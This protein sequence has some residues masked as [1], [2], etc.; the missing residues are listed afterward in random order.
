M[1][2]SPVHTHTGRPMSYHRSTSIALLLAALLALPAA[3]AVVGANPGSGRVATAT[4]G[5]R[6]VERVIVRWASTAGTERGFSRAMRMT[7]AH[8]GTRRAAVV[9]D[10]TEAW[11]LPAPLSGADLRATLD[12][13]AATPGVA[14]VLVDRRVTA[15]L[16][17]NDPSFSSQWDMG[18]GY[19]VHATTAWDTTT[20]SAATVVAVIDTGI[21][22]HS[23]FTGRVVAGYDFISDV[24]QAND[25]NGPDPD[26]SDPGDWITTAENASGYFQG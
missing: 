5:S 3:P 11:W 1:C 12:E 8:A 26:A 24:Q 19:G 20:G 15:D 6:P 14:E 16:T 17:P 10:N 9:S 18:G 21:T 2:V 7:S 4:I 22:T 13:I 23:E 25:G